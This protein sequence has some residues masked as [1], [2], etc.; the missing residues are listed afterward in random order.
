MID[1]KTVTISDKEIDVFI[2]KFFDS[3]LLILNKGVDKASNPEEIIKIR[4]NLQ[5]IGNMRANPTYFVT[6]THASFLVYNK[7]LSNNGFN[8]N[9]LYYTFS[10]AVYRISMY[11]S[12]KTSQNTISM[13]D[14]ISNWYKDVPKSPLKTISS[15]FKGDENIQLILKHKKELTY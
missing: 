8:H 13:F 12:N 14:A 10:S 9:S 4:E 6:H 3:A 5:I 7:T 2:K 15:I 11:Y 1:N